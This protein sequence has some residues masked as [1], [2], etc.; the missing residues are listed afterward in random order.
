MLNGQRSMSNGQLLVRA[1]PSYCVGLHIGTVSIVQ[2][3]PIGT[4]RRHSEGRYRF[5][6]H[7]C[8]IWYE[9]TGLAVP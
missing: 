2:R 7:A 9:T 8:M 5:E 4:A 1:I 3:L 6:K